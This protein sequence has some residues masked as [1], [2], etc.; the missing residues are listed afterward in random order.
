M[1][2]PMSNGGGSK[3]SKNRVGR[4]QTD[5]QLLA[6]ELPACRWIANLQSD[7]QPADRHPAQRRIDRCRWISGLQL[8]SQLAEERHSAWRWIDSCKRTPGLQ[9]DS[10]PADEKSQPTIGQ[11]V[12]MGQLSYKSS[13]YNQTDSLQPADSAKLPVDGD[14]ACLP[15]DT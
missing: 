8:D 11:S 9:T 14:P 2:G 1:S 13:A 12:A 6:D 3:T 10:Q 4:R 15:M 5:C 7:S